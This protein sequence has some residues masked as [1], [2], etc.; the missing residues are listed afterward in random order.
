MALYYKRTNADRILDFSLVVFLF[1]FSVSIVLP[2]LFIIATS[3]SDPAELTRGGIFFLPR[4]FSLS[5]YR[6]VLSSASVQLGY[7]NTVFRTAVGTLLGVF[8]GAVVAFPLAK[9]SL[10]GRTAF[11]FFFVF[12]M[13]F[14]GG[15]IPSFLLVRNLGLLDSRWA[16]VLPLVHNTWHIV[17]IRNFFMSLPAELEESA[18][19]DGADP[20]T[21]L[22]RIILPMSKAVLATVALWTAVAHWNAWFD[23]LIYIRT[24]SKQVMQVQLRRLVIEMNDAVM[25]DLMSTQATGG[26]IS[27][28]QTIRAAMIMVTMLPMLMVYPFI[29]KYFVK[30]VMIGALKG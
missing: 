28:E 17:I 6:D 27:N 19:I 24:L 7:L 23:S 16:L 10:P 25:R 13:F 5:A 22:A 29:Q 18:E 1:L 8:L 2:F 11:T 9:R 4:G 30:G 21:I 3:L 15:L 12:T 20:V 14:S 26:T